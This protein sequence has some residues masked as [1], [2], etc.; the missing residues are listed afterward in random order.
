MGDSAVSSWN[1]LSIKYACVCVYICVC[2]CVCVLEVFEVPFSSPLMMIHVF[3]NIPEEKYVL[4][5]SYEL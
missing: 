2:V 5:S 4:S 3:E 1:Y